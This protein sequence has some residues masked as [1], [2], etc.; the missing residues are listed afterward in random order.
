MLPCI[1]R[2]WRQQETNVL[3]PLAFYSNWATKKMSKIY[4]QLRDKEKKQGLQINSMEG[5]IV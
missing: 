3:V 5:T 2:Y 4:A 1:S